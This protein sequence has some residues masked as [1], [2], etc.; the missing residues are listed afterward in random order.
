MDLPNL[1]LL[2]GWKVATEKLCIG[3]PNFCVDWRLQKRSYV[4]KYSFWNLPFTVSL[5][6]YM[7][8]PSFILTENDVFMKRQL[9]KHHQEEPQF[10]YPLHIYVFFMEIMVCG[11][12]FQVSNIWQKSHIFFYTRI[13]YCFYRKVVSEKLEKSLG[14]LVGS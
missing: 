7:N 6:P 5:K 14:V 3:W 9:E 13:L 12:L 11:N 1:K 2:T 4:L 8:Y 10:L